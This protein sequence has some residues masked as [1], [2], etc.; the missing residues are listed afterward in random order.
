[1][2]DPSEARALL[3]SIDTSTHAGL[4]DRALI[5]LMVYSF[6][7]IGAALGM[8]VEDVFTQ[9]RRLWVRLHEKGGKRHAMPCHHN[10]EEYLISY[11]DGASL[12]DDPKGAAVPHDRPRHRHAHRYGPA[13][14]ERLCDDPAARG[15]RRHRNQA[16]QSQLP[17]D[18]ERVHRAPEIYILCFLA[19]S[20]AAVKSHNCYFM[21]NSRR[22]A[23]ALEILP[24]LL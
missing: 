20:G 7:R 23:T 19:R 6:A 3:D 17:G 21:E 15:R 14:G 22:S 12:R 13:A 24:F 10:L 4:R 5:G 9:N 1:M 16:R 18:G 11:L 8:T 2:L